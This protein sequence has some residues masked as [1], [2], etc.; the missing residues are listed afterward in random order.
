MTCERW[1]LRI[2]TRCGRLG[3][4]LELSGGPT[5]R[6]SKR[7]RREP[8]GTAAARGVGDHGHGRLL[9]CSAG[10]S[11]Q[12]TCSTMT[13]ALTLP[14]TGHP[15]TA[16]RRSDDAPPTTCGRR[17]LPL[18]VGRPVPSAPEPSALGS[19]TV[20]LELALRRRLATLR[21]VPFGKPVA[22]GTPPRAARPVRRRPARRGQGGRPVRESSP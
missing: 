3:A 13:V 8:L 1:D 7:R 10:T 4:R 17:P 12:A 22:T 14:T 6:T 11:S 16:K 15:E 5:R 21:R 20:G 9:G 18:P 2:R 19:G